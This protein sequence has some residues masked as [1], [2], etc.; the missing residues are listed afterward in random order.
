MIDFV[1]ISNNFL[2]HSEDE[3]IIAKRRNYIKRIRKYRAEGRPIFYMD[4][5]YCN[6]NYTPTKMWHD[7]S[8]KSMIDVRIKN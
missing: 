6:A 8:I 2:L 7:F 1:F 4:E 5:T 3:F